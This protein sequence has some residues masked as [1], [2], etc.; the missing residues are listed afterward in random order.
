MVG[1]QISECCYPNKVKIGKEFNHGTIVLNVI[2][3]KEMD[4]EYQ[5]RDIIDKINSFFGHSLIKEIKLRIIQKNSEKNLK[6]KKEKNMRKEF[7]YNL[8]NINS[9][10]LKNSLN[11]L[12][13]AYNKKND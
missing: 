12:I 13:R 9:D 4:I 8:E 10:Q 7:K 6:I 2:H 5:K 3:G 11:G 1:K